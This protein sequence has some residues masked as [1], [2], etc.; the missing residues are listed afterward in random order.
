MF[1]TSSVKLQIFRAKT[2]RAEGERDKSPIKI[3][4]FKIS[5]SAIDRTNMHKIEYTEQHYQPT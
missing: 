5:F 4:D 1:Y 2:D 3:G